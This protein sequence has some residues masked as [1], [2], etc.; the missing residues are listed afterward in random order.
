LNSVST[1]DGTTTTT[2]SCRTS[3]QRG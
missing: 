3:G 1:K 2:S